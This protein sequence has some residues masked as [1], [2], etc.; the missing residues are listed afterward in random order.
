MFYNVLK[1]KELGETD[2]MFEKDF[3]DREAEEH[4]YLKG[5]DSYDKRKLRKMTH[6]E[7]FSWD[8]MGNMQEKESV[9][10]FDYQN[11]SPLNYQALA[12]KI[13]IDGLQK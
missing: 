5:Y 9:I 2:K 8:V 13:K 12:I 3:Y 6:L 7:K 11:R 1:L 4:R 10:L